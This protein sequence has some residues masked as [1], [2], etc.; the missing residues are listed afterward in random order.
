M[1]FKR[2]G[3]E[4]IEL[5]SIFG[6]VG[7]RRKAPVHVAKCLHI[8]KDTGQVVLSRRNISQWMKNKVI[9]T[10][11]IFIQKFAELL[12]LSTTDGSDNTFLKVDNL[13]ES[14]RECL[15]KGMSPSDDSRG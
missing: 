12:A 9:G 13:R 15:V 11:Q 3:R 4:A 10:Y 7:E 8:T 6:Q 2:R 14:Y 5:L 1:H